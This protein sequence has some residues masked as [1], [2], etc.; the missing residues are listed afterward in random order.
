MRKSGL[1]LSGIKENNRAL[2]LQMICTAGQITR[3]ELAARS[4]LSQM[5]VTNIV[6]ELLGKKLIEELQPGE[7]AKLPGRTPMVLRVCA[8]APVILGVFISRCWIYGTIGDFSMHLLDREE[9]ALGEV[10][11]EQTVLEKLR[12]LVQTLIARCERTICGIGVATVGA[13]NPE[14]GSIAY[15]TS[16]YGI[17]KLPVADFLRGHFP[18]PVYVANDMQAAGLCELYFGVGREEDDFL[19]VG[20]TNGVGAALI[21]NRELFESHGEM[22]HMSINCNG[23]QCTCGNTGCLELYVSTPRILQRIREDCGVQLSTMQQA[24]A[25]A[26]EDRT[27]YTTLYNALRRLGYG[28]NNY[29]NLINV[30]TVVLGHDAFFLTD[31][32]I[33][34]MQAHIESTGIAVHLMDRELHI[35]RSTFED[36]A[37]LYGSLCVFLQRIFRGDYPI[38]ELLLSIG[39][40][41]GA[42]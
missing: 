36:I 13:V 31:E 18:Y 8:H 37:P 5:T 38:D 27:A 19:Y 28:I 22:G 14:N 4:K 24:V 21:S 15:I 35:L 9:V 39:Q 7:H 33:A 25:L 20:I 16:F 17:E 34:S 3:S 6:N 23:P 41:D 40:A 11:S 30:P 26:M 2:I 1:N 42:V 10:E 12:W 29:L 32:L